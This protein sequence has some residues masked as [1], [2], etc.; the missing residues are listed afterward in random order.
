MEQLQLEA[1]ERENRA[2]DEQYNLDSGLARDGSELE[3]YT[4][5][6]WEQAVSEA[7]GLQKPK[8]AVEAIG[9]FDL[10]GFAKANL[11]KLENQLPQPIGGPIF[12]G[13]SETPEERGRAIK[14]HPA[15]EYAMQIVAEHEAK[16]G[17]LN[18]SALIRELYTLVDN[19][20]DVPEGFVES[21]LINRG[22]D[23]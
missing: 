6:P 20:D 16:P 15:W 1:A 19:A 11:R 13:A 23:Q 3:Q 21:V 12:G 5:T 18:E 4:R 2:A 22:Y 8:G 14:S 7:T 9:D 17:Q 10:F